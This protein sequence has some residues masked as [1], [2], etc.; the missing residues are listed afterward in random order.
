MDNRTIAIE[1][2]V[3][4][5]GLRIDSTSTAKKKESKHSE[6]LISHNSKSMFTYEMHSFRYQGQK[7]ERCCLS[8]KST[9]ICQYATAIVR[10]S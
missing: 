10:N 4:L 6:I 1:D 3:S 5:N 8:Y 7:Y 9:A 2:Y